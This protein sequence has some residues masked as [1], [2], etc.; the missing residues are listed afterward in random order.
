MPKSRKRKTRKRPSNP[1][2]SPIDPQRQLL[3]DGNAEEFREAMAAILAAD[4]AELRGDALSALRIMRG[5]STSPDGRAFWRPER[6]RRLEQVVELG[7][8]SL[9]GWVRSRWVQAQAQQHL[10]ESSRGPARRALEHA[11]RARGGVAAL[12]GLDSRDAQCKVVDHD[13]L[14]RQL[15]LFEFEG[16]RDFLREAPGDLLAGAERIRDWCGAPM[17]GYRFVAESP[18]TLTWI[19][20][21][22]GGEVE[23]CNLGAS[24]L[25]DDGECAIGRVV[26]RDGIGSMFE[27]APLHVPELVARA[28]ADQPSDW[29]GA[30]TDGFR[31]YGVMPTRAKRQL[32]GDEIFVSGLHDFGLLTDVPWGIVS[33]FADDFDRLIEATGPGNTAL[34]SLRLESANADGRV[35]AAVKVCVLGRT[36]AARAPELAPRGLWPAVGAAVTEPGVVRALATVTRPDYDEGWLALARFLEEPAADL[37]LELGGL[38][39]GIA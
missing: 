7:P 3:H 34:G 29:V 15:L 20:L 32:A 12:P 30:L 35:A 27:C 31:D 2:H 28:V 25:V 26:P 37:L 19:E 17:G 6:L 10:S 11:T 39:W 5:V 36:F 38:G 9:P 14:H 8:A 33:T 21:A 23:V 13:W 24:V 16:L 18:R 4:E 1:R 22:T